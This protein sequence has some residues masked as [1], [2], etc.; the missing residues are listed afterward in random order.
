[1]TALD[2]KTILDQSALPFHDSENE[3]TIGKTT[4]PKDG[5]SD[6]LRVLNFVKAHV[7]EQYASAIIAP[8]LKGQHW[9]EMPFEA[10]Y[11]FRSAFEAQAAGGTPLKAKANNKP[12]ELDLWNGAFLSDVQE[13]ED[14]EGFK[15]VPIPQAREYYYNFSLKPREAKAFLDAQADQGQWAIMQCDADCER[16]KHVHVV[17]GR[18]LSR[19]T[20]QL[21]EGD[22]KVISL[23]PPLSAAKMG[24]VSLQVNKNCVLGHITKT[25][26]AFQGT[27]LANGATS[28]NETQGA[29]P[30]FDDDTY[31]NAFASTTYQTAHEACVA[32]AKGG[33]YGDLQAVIRNAK[34]L[35]WRQLDK[36]VATPTQCAKLKKELSVA[37]TSHILPLAQRTGGTDMRSLLTECI[38]VAVKWGALRKDNILGYFISRL[39]EP[40]HNICTIDGRI[41]IVSPDDLGGAGASEDGAESVNW[42]DL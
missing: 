31:V 8:C 24:K 22:T 9:E 32:L 3:F 42:A 5:Y 23:A 38:K 15:M 6:S 20:I 13:Y 10:S 16:G 36:V 34:N 4:I 28:K 12:G 27:L 29:L 39:A 41:V 37:F 30:D 33:D 14:D 18:Y 19:W 11:L 40:V 1:M 21:G 25:T 2:C 17:S 7:K 35:Q 26:K